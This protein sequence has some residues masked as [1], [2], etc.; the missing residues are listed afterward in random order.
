MVT[1]IDMDKC[2]LSCREDTESKTMKKTKLRT[3]ENVEN[4][5]KES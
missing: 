3:D 2:Y 5:Q 1:L 4:P